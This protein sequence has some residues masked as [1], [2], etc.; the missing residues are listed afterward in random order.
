MFW[1]EAMAVW[2][3]GGFCVALI[4]GSIIEEERQCE[5]KE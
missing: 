1:L 4:I 3:L 2:T 5:T